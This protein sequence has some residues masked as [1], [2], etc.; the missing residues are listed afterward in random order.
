MSE[1]LAKI[2]KPSAEEFRT[3]RKLLFVPLIFSPRETPADF[4]ELVNRYW[5]QVEA[6]ISKLEATLSVVH[7]VY[8]EMIPVGGKEG[9]KAIKELNCGS[10]PITRTRLKKKAKLQPVEDSELLMEFMDWSKCLSIGLQ[11]LKAIT[12][13]YEAY[14]EAQKNRN[15]HIAKQIDETLKADETALLL[16]REGHQVQFPSDI[17]VFYVAPPSLDEIKRWLRDRPAEA[18]TPEA[19]AQKPDTE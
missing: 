19:E 3:G 16:M 13:V 11:S 8:H 5:E 12:L 6:H 14:A 7:K 18:Q 4:A 17:Q 2:E 10:Y 15:L 9:L 1:P